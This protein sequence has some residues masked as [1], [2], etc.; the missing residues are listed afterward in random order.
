M[1]DSYAGQDRKCKVL[2]GTILVGICLALVGLIGRLVYINTSLSDDLTVLVKAQQTGFRRVPGRRGFIFDA[3]GRIV[4]GTWLRPSVFADPALI[5]D[6][7]SVAKRLAPILDLPA[8]QIEQILREHRSGRFCWLRRLV[9]RVDAEAIQALAIPGVGLQEEPERIFPME[10]LMAQTVGVVGLDGGGLEG[11]ELVYDKHLRGSDGRRASVYDGG[12]RRRPIWLHEGLSVPERD[13]GHVVLTLDGVIQG[14]VEEQLQRT[15]AE[16][17]A[18]SGVGLVMS[19]RT[20]AI[21]AMG[22]YPSFDPNHYDHSPAALRRN[23]LV[24]D[25]VEPGSTF[26][27][28]VACGALLA[29]VVRRDERIFCYNGVHSF[30]GRVMH[31]S[32]PHGMLTFE[33][34]ITQS[35]NIGMGII[36]ERMGNLAVHNIVRAFGF[37]RRTG[38]EFPG[39]STGRLRP[40]SEW[41]RYSTTSIPI[42]QEIAVTP[43]QLA[44]AFSAI[45]NGGQLL[46][47]YLVKALLSPD[48]E[49]IESFEGGQVVRRVLPQSLA[50]FLREEVLVGVVERGGG[51]R[52]AMKDW[53]MAGKTGTAQ[54]SY[55]DQAGYEPGAY[56]ASFVG[57][58]PAHDPQVVV[59]V[60]IH[61]P[62][63]EL[64]Y[65]GGVVA[66]PAVREI[67]ER[68]LAYLEV[69]QTTSL[70]G[71]VRGSGMGVGTYGYPDL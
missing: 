22:Q 28:Y 11:M 57:A 8:G 61:K 13:G 58:G 53:Q 18:E 10:A 69:C 2:G 31:D 67:M 26:K 55:Q 19:P 1:E 48:G 68:T 6:I 12:R 52:A 39:E 21:L 35:S 24:C 25:S 30:G 16:F 56:L 59:L 14:F 4:A 65:Y 46:K 54:V 20:G 37:G 66:A 41:T 5:H 42:G 40:L 7:Q 9:D 62:R 27:P 3:A 33:E 44:T 32:S 23:R 50:D 70:V 36:A 45:V 17:E 38:I 47:P 34:I 64:G 51:R 71:R 60:M 43:L 15:V 63:V 29:G 49:V